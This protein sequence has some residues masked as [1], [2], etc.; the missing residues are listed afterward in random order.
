MTS[1]IVSW[2]IDIYADSPLEAAQK[3]LECQR[4]PDSTSVVFVVRGDDNSS[5]TI[6]LAEGRV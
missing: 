2:D 5:T 4:D 3:A 6:D 1:Y